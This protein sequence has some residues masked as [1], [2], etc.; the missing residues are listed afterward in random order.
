VNPSTTIIYEEPPEDEIADALKKQPTPA[1]QA[2]GRAAKKY[3]KLSR[4]ISMS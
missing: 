2:K 4:A 1:I 3:S